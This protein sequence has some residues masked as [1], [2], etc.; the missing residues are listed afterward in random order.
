MIASQ[1]PL[2]VRLAQPASSDA[3]GA[4][5]LCQ[6]IARLLRPI[7]TAAVRAALTLSGILPV[8]A[9]SSVGGRVARAL[10]PRLGVS[11]RARHNLRLAF[12]HMPAEDVERII[13]GMWEN[14]GRT[15]AEYPHLPHLG[16]RIELIGSDHVARALARNKPII[17]FAAH[18]GNWEI[19]PS[20]AAQLGAPVH[21]V[22][23]RLNNS[24]IDALLTRIRGRAA[25]TTLIPR[26]IRG[27]RLA[28]RR[29]ADGQHLALLLD[30]RVKRGGISVPFFGRDTMTAPTV[31]RLALRFDCSMLPVQ[32]ERLDGARFRLTV[33]SAVDLPRTGNRT[34]DARAIMLRINGIIEDW[35]RHRPDQWL[36]LHR[37]WTNG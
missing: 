37:R 35:I 31:A 20:V 13:R 24:A 1:D 28:F 27:A 19:G 18:M 2:P 9:A 10:G 29:L 17:F 11:R 16:R 23:R 14:L 30:Q 8:D 4:S 22:Y 32:I 21:L 5:A 34:T 6:W 3:P 33:H 7:E 36:W 15:A 25:P 26:G 12:P